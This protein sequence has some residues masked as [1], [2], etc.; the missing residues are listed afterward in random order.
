MTVSGEV[1]AVS[2]L[3]RARK[4][5]PVIAEHRDEGERDRCLPQ[6]SHEAMRDAGLYWLLLPEAYGGPGVDFVTTLLVIEEISRQDGAAGW[7]LMIGMQGGLFS[8]YLPASGATPIF[9]GARSI[10]AGNFAPAGKAE[11]VPGGYRLSGHWTFASGCRH[12]NWL[13]CGSVIIEGGRPRVGPGEVPEIRL[14]LVSAN[15][16]TIID[17]WY[18][19]GMKGTGSNDF[20]VNDAFVPED[21]AFLFP[22]LTVGPPRRPG[23]GYTQPFMLLAAP[24]M[25]MVALGIARDAIDS[26]KELAAEKTPTG[27]TSRLLSQHVVHE[28]VGLAEALVGSARAYVLNASAQLAQTPQPGDDLAAQVRLASAYAAR[29]AGEAVDL[30]YELGGGTVIYNRSRLDR[31]F[32]DIHTAAHHILLSPSNIEMVGQYHLGLGLQMRR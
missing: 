17:S 9:E 27:A 28:K 5:Q 20:E 25:A 22:L 7:N 29:A 16:A 8:D 13:I 15:Q 11:L 26:L 3:D 31:C 30:M 6:P 2:F 23:I 4:I 12:A 24:G 10:V 14:M 21:R 19:G 18:T 32:R 1:N